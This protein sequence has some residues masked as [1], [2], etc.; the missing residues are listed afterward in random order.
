MVKLAEM[1]EKLKDQQ[2]KVVK[3]LIEQVK[4]RDE[5]VQRHRETTE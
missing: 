4:V 5:E 1:L 2:E 3:P